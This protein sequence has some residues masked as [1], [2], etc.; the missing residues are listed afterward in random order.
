MALQGVIGWK[1]TVP[2]NPLGVDSGA[3]IGPEYPTLVP[4]ISLTPAFENVSLRG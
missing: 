1:F 3:A 2:I 4:E